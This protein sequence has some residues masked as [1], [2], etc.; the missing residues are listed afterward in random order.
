MGDDTQFTF[1][2]APTPA[3]LSSASRRVVLRRAGW[4][5]VG[6]GVLGVVVGGALMAADGTRVVGA[7]GGTFAFVVGVLLPLLTIARTTSALR[8]AFRHPRTYRVDA[9]GFHESAADSAHLIRWPTIEMIDEVGPDLLVLRVHRRVRVLV[10]TDR[11]PPE[12]R[13][14]MLAF[15]RDRLA[16]ETVE[17]PAAVRPPVPGRDHR[18]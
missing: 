9:R 16:G 14:E 12:T 3:Q 11:M 7:V 13:A 5:Q 10:F 1:S 17:R 2:A 6:Y 15:A 18:P 4:F 8:S